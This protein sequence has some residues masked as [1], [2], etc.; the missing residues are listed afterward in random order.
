MRYSDNVGRQVVGSF[1]V[2][3]NIWGFAFTF[4]SFQSYY[5]NTLLPCESASSISWIG[6]VSSFL[7]ICIGVVSGPIFDLGYFRTCLFIGAVGQTLGVMLMSISDK[8]WQ[9]FL[10]QGLLIGITTG[11][12]YLPSLTLVGRSFKR[13]RAVAL[14]ISS[15]GVC[16]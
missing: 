6:T 9:L 4:G 16:Q 10:T 7:L 8:Y 11:L 13:Q 5:Q 1:L 15:C 2:F 14:A 3:A 12:L